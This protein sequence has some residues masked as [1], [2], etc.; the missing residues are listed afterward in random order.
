MS[1]LELEMRRGQTLRAE[2]ESQAVLARRELAQA[3]R[4]FGERLLSAEEKGKESERRANQLMR[5][6]EALQDALEAPPP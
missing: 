1:R 5:E 4:E 2:A 6:K 3:R